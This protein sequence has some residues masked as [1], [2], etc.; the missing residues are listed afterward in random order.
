MIAFSIL[1]FSPITTSLK[2][3]EFL[4]IEPAPTLTPGDNTERS[5]VPSIVQP[6]EINA[7]VIVAWLPTFTGGK[8]SDLV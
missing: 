7:L 8:S 2:I 5:T 4:T 6:F 1:Q 3:T